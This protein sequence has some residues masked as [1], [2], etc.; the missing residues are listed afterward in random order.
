MSVKHAPD[1]AAFAKQHKLILPVNHQPRMP[2]MQACLAPV[3]KSCVEAGTVLVETSNEEV[4]KNF[5]YCN[6]FTLLAERNMDDADMFYCKKTNKLLPDLQN[7]IV[8][9]SLSLL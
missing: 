6:M 5:S 9:T 2:A 8:F 4:N 1:L 3:M 7:T